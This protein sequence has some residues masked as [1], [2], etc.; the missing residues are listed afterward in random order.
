MQLGVLVENM[1][2][3]G[4]EI[5][6]SPP[7]VVT[8]AAD[9]AADPPGGPPLSMAG[10]LEPYEDVWIEVDDEH[11]G[12]VIDKLTARKGEILGVTS[13][14]GRTQLQIVAP[15]RSMFGFRSGFFSDTRGSGVLT[16]AFK[17][18]RAWAGVV[19]AQR[20][21]ALL[22][23]AAG[24]TT[25]YALAGI[26]P[27][28]VLFVTTGEQVYPGQVRGGGCRGERWLLVAWRAG[29]IGPGPLRVVGSGAQRTRRLATRRLATLSFA[30]PPSARPPRHTL[31]P[32]A[33]SFPLSPSRPSLHSRVPLSL[34][35]APPPRALR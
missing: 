25:P 19:S 27:R 3:E 7:R 30:S 29:R 1:R 12:A 2:R 11:A 16:T 21:G 31:L 24:T 26:E 14:L 10:R 34:P 28:G 23:T 5:C 22:S 15:A 8:I 20:K 13:A 9:G 17:E 33:S 18:Y 35:S 4:Y 6:I 32:R